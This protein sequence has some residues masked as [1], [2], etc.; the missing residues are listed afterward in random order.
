MKKSKK[1]VRF[2]YLDVGEYEV[3]KYGIYWCVWDEGYT[4]VDYP[5]ENRIQDIYRDIAELKYT[6]EYGARFVYE[7]DGEARFIF[8]R[9][10]K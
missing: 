8:V 3:A 9:E 5:I 10:V 6:R 4:A 1:I 2:E 7:K